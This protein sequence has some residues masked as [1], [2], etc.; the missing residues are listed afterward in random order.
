LA[1]VA[2]LSIQFA[3]SAGAAARGVSNPPRNDSSALTAHYA[4]SM[5]AYC[6][7]DGAVVGTALAA[8]RAVHPHAVPTRA[9]LLHGVGGPFLKSWPHN[10]PF[11]GYSISSNGRLLLSIPADAQTVIYV[12]PSQ[13]EP[14]KGATLAKILKDESC[15][16]DGASVAVAMAAFAAQNPPVIPNQSLLDGKKYGGPYLSGWPHN[17]PWYAFSITAHGALLIAV[18]ASAK[19]KAYTNLTQCNAL[20]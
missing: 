16:A 12:N 10:E 14:L 20:I 13:C 8:Y 3:P 4:T 17:R 2:V 11:Y 1:I 6:Q 9:L 5:V 19:P 7:I 15:R 18:P